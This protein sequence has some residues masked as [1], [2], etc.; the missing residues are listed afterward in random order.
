MSQLRV[1]SV[2]NASGTG[3][4]YAPGHVVQVVSVTKTD[5]F[6]T[7]AGSTFTDI[8]GLSATITPKLNTSKILVNLSLSGVLFRPGQNA[9]AFRIMRDSTAIGIGDAAGSRNRTSIGGTRSSDDSL[10]TV[11]VMFLDSP[12]TT[13]ATTYKV[14][15]WQDTPGS[16]LYINRTVTDGDSA[17]SQRSISTIT[18]MEIA[19]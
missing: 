2:T 17:A 11:N 18:L 6:T 10:M 16:P 13:S 5:T 1:N 14:Q 4:T 9:G 15:L 3:S 8:T 7:A 12:A 19:Q